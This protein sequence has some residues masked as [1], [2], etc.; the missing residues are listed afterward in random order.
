[1]GSRKAAEELSPERQREIAL[2]GIRDERAIALYD[3]AIKALRE[4]E[5]AG[6]AASVQLRDA[7]LWTETI[8]QLQGKLQAALK[9]GAEGLKHVEALM[10]AKKSAEDARA[11]IL[12][13]LLLTPQRPRGRPPKGQ[14][15]PEDPEDDGWDT[16][17][18][19]EA[20]KA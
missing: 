9:G 2:R 1:M 3:E 12:D 7:C 11:R 6:F 16:F 20:S 8:S 19:H 4:R 18:A 13:A 10:R 15:D 14:D 17:D 5:Q